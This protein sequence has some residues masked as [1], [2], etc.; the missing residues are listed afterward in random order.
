MSVYGTELAS[1]DD[2]HY[3][4]YLRRTQTLA[5]LPR[6]RGRIKAL[7]PDWA[8]IPEHARHD[9]RRIAGGYVD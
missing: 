7:G 3:T 9:R 4:R 2:G 8:A 1:R 6:H 5:S